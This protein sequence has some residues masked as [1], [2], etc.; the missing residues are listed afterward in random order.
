VNT[1]SGAKQE[2]DQK[3]VAIDRLIIELERKALG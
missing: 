2:I 1:F 3:I